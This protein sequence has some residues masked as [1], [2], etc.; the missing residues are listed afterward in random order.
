[1]VEAV[2]KPRFITFLLVTFAGLALL[3][4]SIGI[5][6]VMSYSVA[7]RTRELGIRM[8]LG[9]QAGGVRALVLREGLL[10]AGLGV[11]LGLAAAAV[12][13]SGLASRLGGILYETAVLDVPTFAVVALVVLAVAALACFVPARRAT[14]VD[15]MVALRHD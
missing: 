5:Y 6:G 10:L 7:Q 4:A 12:V 3:L 1:M 11:A 9:A 13:N 15:P 8:A 14:R 2:G